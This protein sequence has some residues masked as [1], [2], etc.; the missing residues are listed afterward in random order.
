MAA[1]PE[2]PSGG[3]VIDSW[4]MAVCRMSCPGDTDR[5]I[6]VAMWDNRNGRFGIITCI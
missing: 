2:G 3:D 5:A 6:P 1:V 4:E